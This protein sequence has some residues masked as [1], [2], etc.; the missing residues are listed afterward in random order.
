MELLRALLGLPARVGQLLT[1]PDA[2]LAREDA[3]G[4]GLRDALAL[5]VA[6]VVAFRFP[7]LVHAVLN[8]AGPTSGALMRTKPSAVPTQMFCSR[9]SRI[10]RM[11]LSGRLDG[12]RNTVT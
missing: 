4:G 8:A 11:L 2:A 5:V 10:A 6:A 7:E 1:A 3:E 9:S 12:A